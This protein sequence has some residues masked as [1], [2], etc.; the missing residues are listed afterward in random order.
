MNEE[1]SPISQTTKQSSNTPH[2]EPVV[3][4]DQMKKD[5]EASIRLLSAI[6]RNKRILYTDECK[7]LLR[8]G[9]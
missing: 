5:I 7:E 6:K 1:S 4:S 3:I 2:N 9:T 8:L